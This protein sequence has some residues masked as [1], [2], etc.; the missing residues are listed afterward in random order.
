MEV[1][2][3]QEDEVT[4]FID[5]LWVPAQREMAAVSRHTLADDIRQDGIVHCHSRL[6]DDESITHLARGENR[7]LG[8]VA[9]EVQTPPPIFQQERE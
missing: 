1:S 5:E 8:Y 2:P 6:S 9:A 4:H 3:F 7:L